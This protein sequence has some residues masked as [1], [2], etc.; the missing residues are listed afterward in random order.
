[1]PNQLAIII[2]AYKDAYLDKTLES[3]ARQTDKNFSVYVGDDNSP[4]DLGKIVSNYSHRLDISYKRFPDNLGSTDLVRHW[5][6]CLD[7]LQGEDF[8]CLF[9]DDDTMEPA[10]VEN[11]YRTL[12]ADSRFDVFH[13]DIDLID[14]GGSVIKSCNNY[15]PVLSAETF[16]R[17]LYTYRIDARMPEFV[18]RTRHFLQSGGFINFDLAYRSDNA[19][20]ITA[21]KDRGIR[22]IPNAKVLW[23]DSGI[24]ISSNHNNALKP[25]RVY[26]T[27]DFFEWME[28]YYAQRAEPCPLSLKERLELIIS[29][30]LT[31]ADSFPRKEL[32]KALGKMKRARRNRFLYLRCSIYLLI[33]LRKNRKHKKYFTYI[34]A[35]CLAPYLKK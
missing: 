17:L 32:Y 2:P 24:N 34:Q 4:H 1:M 27:I 31:L 29:D 3:L 20:V 12:G 11:F 16:V 21:A 8:F 35:H 14:A 30:I 13:F 7:M 15:P 6:R 25:R 33:A 22:T 18:F 5:S 28:E 26:A 10:C 23:R 9:S 19:T